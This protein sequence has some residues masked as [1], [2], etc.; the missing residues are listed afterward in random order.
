MSTLLDS[1]EHAGPAAIQS[2]WTQVD[3][4]RMHARVDGN[5]QALPVVLVHGLGVS[6][7]YF[8]PSQVRLAETF[9]VYAPDLPGFGR[10]DTPPQVL[11]IPALAGSLAGWLRANGLVGVALVGNSMGCQ[12]IVDMAVREPGLVSRAVLSGPTMD[13]YARHPFLQM[14]RLLAVAPREHPAQVVLAVTEYLQSGVLRNMR[15]LRHALRDPIEAKL[16]LLAMPVMVLRGGRDPIVSQ[17][18]AERASALL[19]NGV[20]RVLEDAPHSS[21]FSVPER[22][23]EAVRPFLLAGS[24]CRGSGVV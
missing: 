11:D 13:P 12:V 14:A 17:R 4:Y 1:D 18:W 15:T 23:T 21:H 6:G 19:P 10:S 22:F 24:G 2:I 7:R 16:P 9:R 5:P 3:G 8:G 20:L